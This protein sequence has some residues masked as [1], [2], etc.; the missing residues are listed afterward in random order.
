MMKWPHDMTNLENSVFFNEIEKP[1]IRYMKSNNFKHEEIRY[2][3]YM[4]NTFCYLNKP[5]L[6]NEKDQN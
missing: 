6:D 4:I 5:R 2:I 3:F 1:L